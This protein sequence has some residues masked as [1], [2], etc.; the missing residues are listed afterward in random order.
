MRQQSNYR[1]KY[2]IFSPKIFHVLIGPHQQLQHIKINYRPPGFP[3]SHCIAVS[4]V[5][6]VK[7]LSIIMCLGMTRRQEPTVFRRHGS[8]AW[9]CCVNYKSSDLHD[10]QHQVQK[11]FRQ[12][13]HVQN[14]SIE[15]QQSRLQSKQQELLVV[16]WSLV[17]FL[18]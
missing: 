12:T 1:L 10:L 8:V 7:V 18:S 14:W 9:L 5:C 2:Q 15:E 17:I 13:S 3:Q 16:Q 11:V 4:A 6:G